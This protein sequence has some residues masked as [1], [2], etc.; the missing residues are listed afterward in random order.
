MRIALIL[1]YSIFFL[2]FLLKF[3]HVHFNAIGMLIG[4]AGLLIAS[5]ALIFFKK[6]KFQALL[7][8]TICCWLIFLFL[9]VKFLPFQFPAL[10]AATFMSIALVVSAKSKQILSTIWPVG[11]CLVVAMLFYLMPADE[12]FKILSVNWNYEIETDYMTWDKY[13]WFLYQNE[14]YETALQVS[15]KARSIAKLLGDNTWVDF[16]EKHQLAIKNKSWE[17]YR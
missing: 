17:T 6:D 2:G 4:L 8:L 15:E 7:H 10:V 5:L 14:K 3:F 12:R 9:T 1:A 13:S 11:I 16:I